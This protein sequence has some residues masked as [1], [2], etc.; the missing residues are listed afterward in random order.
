MYLAAHVAVERS[1]PRPCL[2]VQG[3]RFRVQGSGFRV[4]GSGFRVQGSGFRVW[5]LGFGG[6]TVDDRDLKLAARGPHPSVVFPE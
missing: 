4:Q 2:R 1:R 3:S 6:F 5:G